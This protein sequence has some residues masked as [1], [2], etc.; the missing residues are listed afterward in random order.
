MLAGHVMVGGVLSESVISNEHDDVSPKALVAV[1]VTA[2]VPRK[3]IAGDAGEHA[4]LKVTPG[5]SVTVAA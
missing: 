4:V 3:K 1:Q 5:L 2:R